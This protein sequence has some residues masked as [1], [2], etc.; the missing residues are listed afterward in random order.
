MSRT[1]IFFLV[2]F[3]GSSLSWSKD[4]LET[5]YKDLKKQET[6]EKNTD[7][8][9][10]GELA[11]F[12][13]IAIIQKRFLPKTGRFELSPSGVFIMNNSF[14]YGY[15]AGANVSYYF[16]EKFA[17]EFTYQKYFYGER[18][19]VKDVEEENLIAQSNARLDQF[20][21]GSIKWTPIYGKIAWLNRKIVPFDLGFSIGGGLA[22]AKYLVSLNGVPSNKEEVKKNTLGFTAGMNQVFALSESL[23]FRWDLGLLY[24]NFKK[25][26]GSK[27]RQIDIYAGAGLSIFFPGVKE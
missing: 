15:G 23:A 13:N 17:A 19:I 12:R 21:G 18:S 22:K 11:Q 5:M 6:Q 1:I 26:G 3:T 14:F 25:D 20:I 7:F 9:K 10:L 8:S 24:Y 4:G 27:V 2:L 16:K